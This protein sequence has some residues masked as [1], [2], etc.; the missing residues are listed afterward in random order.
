MI[1]FIVLKEVS[2]PSLQERKE[3]KDERRRGGKKRERGGERMRAVEE[4]REDGGWR[5][6]KAGREDIT[7]ANLYYKDVHVVMGVI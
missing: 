3:K 2:K 4:E 6:E 7:C 1:V 5:K